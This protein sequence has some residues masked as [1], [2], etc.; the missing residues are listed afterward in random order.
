[1]AHHETIFIEADDGTDRRL[2]FRRCLF[3]RALSRST[4]SS[5]SLETA[6]VAWGVLARDRLNSVAGRRTSAEYK[7]RI[8][9]NVSGLRFETHLST[10]ERFSR[11]L[12]GDATRRER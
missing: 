5:A 4:G 9:V 3:V 10:V 1:M 8:I 11:T 7:H 6:C 2:C 12:L